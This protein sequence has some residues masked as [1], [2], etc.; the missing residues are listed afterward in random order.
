MNYAADSS[1]P[2]IN[3]FEFNTQDT[4]RIIQAICYSRFNAKYLP[5]A[6]HRPIKYPTAVLHAGI[7]RQFQQSSPPQ[8]CLRSSSPARSAYSSVVRRA[9]PLQSSTDELSATKNHK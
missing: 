6:I 7:V 5:G 9:N 8:R 2:S 1:L 4:P 3:A